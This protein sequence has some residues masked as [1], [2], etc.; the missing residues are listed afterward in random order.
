MTL[1]WKMTDNSQLTNTSRSDV[2]GNGIRAKSFR[3]L[4]L[5]FGRWKRAV[6]ETSCVPSEYFVALSISKQSFSLSLVTFAL[7]KIRKKFRQGYC[8]DIYKP[9]SSKVCQRG[10]RS[11][12]GH[13]CLT[14]FMANPL[15][16]WQ[17]KSSYAQKIKEIIFTK[18]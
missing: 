11:K 4:E 9:K 18:Y 14:S 12:D 13:N 2:Y 3:I 15:L 10:S 17:I 6:H 7:S 5:V 1:N 16:H 8:E